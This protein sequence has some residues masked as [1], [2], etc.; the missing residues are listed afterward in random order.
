MRGDEEMTREDRLDAA[1]DRALRS[2][3]EPVEVPETRVVLARLMERVRL[4]PGH[5]FGWLNWSAVV[6]AGLAVVLLVGVV[7]MM[8]GARR[9]EIAWTPRAPGVVQSTPQRLKPDSARLYS[10][11]EAVPLQNEGGGK[12]QIAHNNSAKAN[13]TPGELVAGVMAPTSLPKLDVFPT[14]RPLTAE[15]QALATFVQQGPPAVQRAVVEDQKH[16]DDPIIVADLRNQPLETSS[17]QDQ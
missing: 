12:S 6:A 11:A 15:E 7:W 16:W 10:T 9:A 8:R 1:I 3:A 4:E 13:R 14:P 17:Q 5:G 2:Y